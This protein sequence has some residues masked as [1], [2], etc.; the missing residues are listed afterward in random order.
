MSSEGVIIDVRHLILRGAR[1]VGKTWLL[2]EFGEKNFRVVHTLNFEKLAGISKVFAEDL[3]PRVIIAGLE[4]ML[5]REIDPENDLIIF[6]EIQAVPRALT[7]LKYFAEE[8]PNYHIAAAGSLLGLHLNPASFPV[9]KV[10]MVDLF[11]MSFQE[12]LDGIGE[13]KLVSVLRKLSHEPLPCNCEIPQVSHELL[14][15][16]FKN[17]LV[18]GGMPEVVSVFAKQREKSLFSAF[19]SVRSK[20]KQLIDAYFSDIAKH[21]GKVN[22]MHI[23]RVLRSVPAQMASGVDTQLPKYVFKDVIPGVRGYERMAAAIDWLQKAGLIVR[24]PIVNSG[25]LPFLAHSSENFFKLA[26]FD[27][28]ILGALAALP[29][30][31]IL[32]Y[33]FGSYKGYFVENFVLQQFIASGLDNLA[34]WREGDSEVEF[35]AVSRSGAAIPIEV[36]A[37]LQTKAKSLGVFR[38]RY[39]PP[40]AI[41]LSGV[42]G[43]REQAGV[44]RWP[45][46][47]AGLFRDSSFSAGGAPESE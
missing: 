45:I 7:S 19:T 38:Q 22:A 21:S 40:Y 42:L 24:L 5:K 41:L 33:D 36:K 32:D 29:P 25:E 46:Y 12:F 3:S 4:L 6:D 9:G 34:C 30:Q 43:R 10:E 23:E 47:T 17:Y 27:V 16:Q 35:L 14:W 28:G 26:L 8:F 15:E 37:G 13:Q 44:Y 18:V 11:P 20:Q 2:R 31:A 39:A 1:Q